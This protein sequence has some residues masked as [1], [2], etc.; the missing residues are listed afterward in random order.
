MAERITAPETVD[1]PPGEVMETLGKVVSE[2]MEGEEGAGEDEVVVT[3]E[4]GR[5]QEAVLP[6][7]EP[8][9]DQR[10]SVEVTEE[11]EGVPVVQVSLVVEQEPEAGRV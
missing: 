1:F 10:Y 11:L 3:A 2:E 4:M 8:T 7:F 9:Q 6:P 5:E